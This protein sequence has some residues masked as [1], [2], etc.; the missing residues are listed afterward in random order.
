[1]KYI[2]I[3]FSLFCLFGLFC[4]TG[5]DDASRGIPVEGKYGA[6]GLVT[7]IQVSNLP[8][9]A[10]LMYNLPSGDGLRYVTAEYYL[11]GEK[12]V[13][14]AS[15]YDNSIRIEGFPA[16][17]EYEVNLYAV[18]WSDVKSAPVTVAV[19]PLEPPYLTTF[20]SLA[21]RPT[22]GGIYV[23]FENENMSNLKISVISPD[24]L[25]EWKLLDTHYTDAPKGGFA[26]RGMTTDPRKFGFYVR[27]RWD[28]YS[29]TLYADLTPLFEME[30][31][32]KNFLWI[33]LPS[34]VNEFWYS[35][36]P[37][38]AW[39]GTWGDGSLRFNSASGSGMP[40]W[41]TIDLGVKADLSRILLYHSPDQS[42]SARCPEI[43]EVWGTNA[44]DAD[45]SWDSWTLLQTFFTK[46]PSG[47][48]TANANDL[49]YGIN[50][51]YD[52]IFEPGIPAVRYIRWKVLKSYGDIQAQVLAELTF[53]GKPEGVD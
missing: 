34:D 16:A 36:L 9:A 26:V 15:Y 30:L 6:P 52:L 13:K 17:G 24:S 37:P 39:D 45:G 22:F 21:T 11:N 20:R 33:R 23:D 29:D 50:H 51:G 8:G 28:N 53:F 40:Q 18:S 19:N 2:K 27:D 31:D 4:L 25:G 35:D 49:D 46:P 43:I 42:F 14:K 44:Y 5:C 12:I 3:L 41:I 38:R 48:A 47:N 32:K 10:V 7:N 1:M